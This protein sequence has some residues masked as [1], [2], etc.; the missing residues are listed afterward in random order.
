MIPEIVGRLPTVLTLN[1]LDEESLLR[2][3]TEPKNAV[4]RQYQKLMNMEGIRLTFA[5]DALREVVKIAHTKKTGARGLRS[6]LES[7]LMPVMF[8][9]PSR[10]DIREILVSRENILKLAAP[11][12]ILKKEKDK[13]IA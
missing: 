7:V 10:D 9:T 1:E 11:V 3:L 6:V 13:K 12:F 4:T 8:E 2:I 5:R